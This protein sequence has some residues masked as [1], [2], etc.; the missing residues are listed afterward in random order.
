M[1]P[2]TITLSTPSKSFAYETL[3]RDIEGISDINTLKDMLR[4][5]VKLYFKQQET[6]SMIG[7]SS[8]QNE[9]I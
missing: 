6:M 8:I 1:N 9:D 4:C 5:Y 7:L 3:S 2:D